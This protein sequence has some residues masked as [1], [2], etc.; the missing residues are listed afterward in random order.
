MEK[1]EQI[2]KEMEEK[3]REFL[4]NLKNY[5]YDTKRNSSSDS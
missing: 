3:M 2:F 4:N 5:D 1:F